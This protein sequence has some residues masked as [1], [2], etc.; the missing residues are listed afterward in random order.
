MRQFQSS[1]EAIIHN[2]SQLNPDVVK[3]QIQT[4]RSAIERAHMELAT[5]DRRVDEIAASQLSD[6]EVD[7]VQLRAQKMAELVLF[8]TEKHSWFD[9]ALSLDPANTPPLSGT[10]AAN[11]R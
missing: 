11:L 9:D 6:V 2:V 8:G 7:G 4:F 10:E 3:T 1:I 5:I